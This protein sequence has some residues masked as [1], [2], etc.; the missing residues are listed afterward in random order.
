MWGTLR[1]KDLSYLSYVDVWLPED[2]LLQSTNAAAERAEAV[3]REVAARYGQEHAES[4]GRPREILAL[5][6]TFAG[7]GGPRFWFS[8][9]PEQQQ[10]SYAQI[11]GLV[12]A[13]YITKLLVP[14]LYAIFV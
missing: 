10:L 7:G 5:L 6:T 12:L 11:G 8:V 2:A 4:E 13:N 9:A 14:A 3:I 1:C